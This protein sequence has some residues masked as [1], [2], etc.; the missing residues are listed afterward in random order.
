MHWWNMWF[1]FD[2]R[3]TFWMLVHITSVLITFLLGLMLQCIKNAN[4]FSSNIDLHP[5]R[6][7]LLIPLSLLNWFHFGSC[8]CNAS[9]LFGVDQSSGDSPP[10]W[11]R[12]CRFLFCKNHCQLQT[13]QSLLLIN[14]VCHVKAK[15]A[16][17]FFFLWEEQIWKLHKSVKIAR[18]E[19]VSIKIH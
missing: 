8:S 6:I 16:T 2:G 13:Q 15:H 7:C 11:H 9:L 1:H 3:W 10:F 14:L 17:T 12:F 19:H 18:W 4:H 5:L